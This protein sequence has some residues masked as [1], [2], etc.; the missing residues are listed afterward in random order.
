MNVRDRLKL[1][2]QSNQELTKRLKRLEK[3]SAGPEWADLKTVA[4]RFGQ[5]SVSTLRKMIRKREIPEEMIKK[6]GNKIVINL[7]MYRLHY[8]GNNGD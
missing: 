2:E 7:P 4:F 3:E 1:L 5:K 8:G 6:D